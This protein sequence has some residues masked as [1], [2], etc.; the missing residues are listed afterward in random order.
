M[1]PYAPFYYLN[2][3]LNKG[4]IKHSF[5]T[6]KAKLAAPQ[7]AFDQRDAVLFEENLPLKRPMANS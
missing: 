3:L 4:E 7:R 5:E 2:Y 1:P 6:K